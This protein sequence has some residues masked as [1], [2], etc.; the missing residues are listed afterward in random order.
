MP[1][2]SHAATPSKPISKAVARPVPAS[3]PLSGWDYAV[4]ED[5]LEKAWSWRAKVDASGPFETRVVFHYK[6]PQDYWALRLVG[7]GKQATLSFWRVVN[8]RA[9][10]WG[11]APAT[12][13][14]AHGELTIQR[15][16]WRV[17]ALWNGHALVSA[18]SDT[19]G[20]RF[21]TATHGGVKLSETRMQPVEAPNFEDDFMR[22]ASPDAPEAPNDWHRV[23]GV[24][25][26]SGLIGPRADAAL[27][28]NPFVFRVEA[29]GAA[30][31]TVGKWFW[32]DYTVTASVRPAL[33][34]LSHP[35]VAG[36]AAYHQ[37]NGA[38]VCGLV[39]FQ[40]GRA[41]LR[42]GNR[43][44]AT[45]APFRVTPNQWHRLFL[46]PGPGVARLLVDGV[47]R[48]RATGVTS[49]RVDLAQG[50]P[51]LYAELGGGN[52]ADFDDVRVSPNDAISDD[53]HTAAVGKWEDAGGEW[54]TRD[55]HRVKIS[56]GPAL[57]LTGNPEREEGRVEATFS[58]IGPQ[59]TW[60]TH[61][62]AA[63]WGSFRGARCT[64]LFPRSQ[65]CRKASG[66][67]WSR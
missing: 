63:N 5:T 54:Q 65:A 19:S 11:E 40:A 13:G 43:T 39:D 26:T 62:Y 30:V 35:L 32:S 59:P 46:E 20:L 10:R 22:A 37:A 15:S 3:L 53:F 55:G 38:M 7:D 29:N 28:P 52:Y 61:G 34:D 16:S 25:K 14:A 8:G 45:S 12:I 67:C 2:I 1:T 23:A 6:S 50:E 51:T 47:E 60:R 4:G 41:M 9:A 36:L 56:A 27:N 49:A 58:Y 66:N 57:T 17:R 18:F 31:T 44:L 21:G 24:W 42:L 48:V 64:Q 33:K